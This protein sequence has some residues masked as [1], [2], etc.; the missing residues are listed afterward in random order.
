MAKK[1]KVTLRDLDDRFEKLFPAHSMEGEEVNVYIERLGKEGIVFRVW[2]NVLLDNFLEFRL[3]KQHKLPCRFINVECASVA[4]ARRY[5]INIQF[6]KPHLTKYE[7]AVLAIQHFEAYFQSLAK[8]NQKLSR[9]RGK[10]GRKKTTSCFER[11]DV[12]E[13]L[14]QKAHVGRGIIL[15]VKKILLE[16]TV[17]DKANAKV[18]SKAINSIYE[19]IKHRKR[20]TPPP[21]HSFRNNLKAGPVDSVICKDAVDGIKCIPDSSVALCVTSPRFNCGRNYPDSV[22]DDTPNDQ[23][24]EDLRILSPLFSRNFGR[25]ADV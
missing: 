3:A 8:K 1:I 20:H 10:K 23:H 17:T 22:C 19:D 4:E 14:A 9:G 24:L 11:V 21:E 6:Q 25:A 15:Q 7:R 13:L 18:E 12:N 16:G 5:A 2:K